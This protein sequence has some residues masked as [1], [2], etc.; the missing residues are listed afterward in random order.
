MTEEV[1]KEYLN[2]I[3]NAKNLKLTIVNYSVLLQGS[4]I[5]FYKLVSISKNIFVILIIVSLLIAV[6]SSVILNALRLD[7]ER[8]RKKYKPNDVKGSE[9]EIGEKIFFYTYMGIVWFSFLFILLF[10]IFPNS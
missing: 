4:I 3:R 8:Y 7:I 1:N 6:L 9:E 5:A 2:D 10:L